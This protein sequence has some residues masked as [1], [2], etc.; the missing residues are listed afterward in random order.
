MGGKTGTT[1]D[2]KNSA[3]IGYAP[4]WRDDGYDPTE[5][6][7]VA[8]YVGYDDNRSMSRGST[9]LQ[10]AS[11][12]LPAWAGAIEAMAAMGLLGQPPADAKAAEDDDELVRVR[13]SEVNGLPL[14]PGAPADEG[15]SVLVLAPADNPSRRFAPF[16]ARAQAAE[17][18]LEPPPLD[19]AQPL[20][21]A[22]PVDTGGVE[23]PRL[24]TPPSVW[25]EIEDDEV[26]PPSP[27]PAEPPPTP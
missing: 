12:A 3:F 16:G 17:A 22:A 26:N 15:A 5:A 18:P 23:E 1:N 24:G 2:Y 10:G 8:S 21:E 25:D 6:L 11:G 9:R 19:L 13:V 20:G 4:I 27:K 14:A 7:T